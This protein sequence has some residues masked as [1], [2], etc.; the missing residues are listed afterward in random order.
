[1]T[2]QEFLEATN[3]HRE[4]VI[5]RPRIH[6]NDGFQ[7]SVQASAYHYCSP[8]ANLKDA[9]IYDSVECGFPSKPCPIILKYAET[10]SD[11]TGT[12]YGYVPIELV[13]QII[14]LHGGIDIEAT[15]RGKVRVEKRFE[16]IFSVKLDIY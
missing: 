12:S 8:K 15:F 14:H 6:C 5:H 13:Q 3:V 1:M 4:I 16:F 7:I 9:T 2:I 10:P 11:P